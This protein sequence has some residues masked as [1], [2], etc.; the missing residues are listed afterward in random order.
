[1][2]GYPRVWNDWHNQLTS[3]SSLEFLLSAVEKVRL[4]GIM[5]AP[6]NPLGDFEP[7][8]G[9]NVKYIGTYKNFE[10]NYQKTKLSSS[11]DQS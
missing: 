2:N 3:V 10:K 8:R 6:S 1:M 11:I 5:Q 9:R 4:F 7:L